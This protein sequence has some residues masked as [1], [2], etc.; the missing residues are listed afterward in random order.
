VRARL[1]LLSE[2]PERW[3][4]AVIEWAAINER[5][6]TGEMPDRNFEYH[7]YQS[8]VGAWPIEK[9]RMLAY[10]EKAA[11][12]AKVHTSWTDPVPAYEDAVRNFID[13]IYDDFDFIESL[14]EFVAPLINA[15]R[16][17]SLAQT[18]VKLT[19]P[20]VP[21]FYQGTELWNLALVDPDNRRPQDF[22]LRRRML[23][24]LRNATPEQ[25]MKRFDEGTPKLWLIRNGLAL[26]KN[27]PEWFGPQAGIEP[28][29]V[30][31]ARRDHVVAFIRGESVVTILPRLVTKLG[32]DWQ[33][34]EVELPRGE[35]MNHLTGERLRGRR[36]KLSELTRRF[37]VAL[38]AREGAQP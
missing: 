29:E 35:W 20:G 2:E 22:D 21:D 12:E 19:A 31:G 1:F 26:R 34:T 9:S 17:N 7:L 24:D 25:V 18:L 32:G 16:I 13:N 28:L 10:A 30:S 8:M 5:H 14:N 37:P 11:R 33:D 3:S 23:A 15:G 38:L 4:R 27:H 6:R 36:I